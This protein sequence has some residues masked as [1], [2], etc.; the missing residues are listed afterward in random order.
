MLVGLGSQAVTTTQAAAF[1]H[2]ASVS[3]GHAFAKTMYTHAAADLWL[4]RSFRHK[5]SSHKKII[6]I[7]L[8]GNEASD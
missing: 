6:A 2:F 8:T 4:I 7:P 5:L 1:Q 3:G